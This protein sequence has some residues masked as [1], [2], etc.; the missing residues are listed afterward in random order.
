MYIKNIKIYKI[1]LSFPKYLKIYTK[2]LKYMSKIGKIYSKHQEYLKYLSI[3]NSNIQ[4]KLIYMFIL[5]TLTYANS[6]QP[7]KSI[8]IPGEAFWQWPDRFL[9]L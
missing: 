1:L 7:C 2:C 6:F 4:T 5:G 9:W 8:W 3:L